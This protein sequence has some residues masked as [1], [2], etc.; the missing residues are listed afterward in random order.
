MRPHNPAPT[1]DERVIAGLDMADQVDRDYTAFVV[2]KGNKIL[3]MWKSSSM[4]HEEV[5]H[6]VRAAV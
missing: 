3:D 6:K 5:A 1:T 4:S 2:R